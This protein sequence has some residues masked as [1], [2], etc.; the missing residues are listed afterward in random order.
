MLARLGTQIIRVGNVEVVAGDIKVE[1]VLKSESDG[2][3]HR[4]INFSIAHER[5]DAWRVAQIWL[6]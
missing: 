1:V 5:V 2:V 6:R 3:V 4:K